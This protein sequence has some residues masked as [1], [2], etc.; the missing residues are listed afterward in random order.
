LNFLA[1]AV[2]AAGVLTFKPSPDS[3]IEP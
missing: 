2:D 3:H 1:L